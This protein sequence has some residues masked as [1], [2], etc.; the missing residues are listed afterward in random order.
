MRRGPGSHCRLNPAM[1]EK[2]C[3]FLRAGNY[4]NVACLCSGVSPNVGKEW[5]ARGRGTTKKSGRSQT[6]LYIAFAEAVEKAEAEAEAAAIMRIQKAARGG[7][8]IKTEVIK[9]PDGTETT[10]T[11]LQ[12]PQW[13]A[14]AWFLERKFHMDW[15]RRDRAEVTG[16]D[17]GAIQLEHG[18]TPALS[19]YLVSLRAWR[20][21]TDPHKGDVVQDGQGNAN[22]AAGRM[23]ILADPGGAGMGQDKDRSG[24]RDRLRD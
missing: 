17:G 2:I 10:R 18:V 12:E 7:S 23:E 4:F 22:L 21:A 14:D 13:T 6:E 16:K 19:E 5:L 9:K 20:G 11:T 15:A 24:E 1:Q 3:Q 8:E